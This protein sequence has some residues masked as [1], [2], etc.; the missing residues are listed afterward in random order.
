MEIEQLFKEVAYL[1]D[2]LNNFN[3]L[4]QKAEPNLKTGIEHIRYD[5]ARKSLTKSPSGTDI[6]LDES[7][8]LLSNEIY[9]ALNEIKGDI[10]KPKEWEPIRHAVKQFI[11][12]H[13]Q[14]LFNFLTVNWEKPASQINTQ[15]KLLQSSV[16]RETYAYIDYQK[17]KLSKGEHLFKDLLKLFFYGLAAG[18]V[19]FLLRLFLSR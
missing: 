5:L 17:F 8:D 4:L 12:T 2:I 6:F 13:F 7:V 15:I 11:E 3:A 18:L 9:S 19:G 1:M 16:L 10:Y 14:L